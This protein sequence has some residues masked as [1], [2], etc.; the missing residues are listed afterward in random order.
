MSEKKNVRIKDRIKYTRGTIIE[1]RGPEN[2][3]VNWRS[4]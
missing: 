3:G 2:A 4:L 1:I